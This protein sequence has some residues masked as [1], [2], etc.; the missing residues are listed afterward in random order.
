[1]TFSVLLAVV[2]PT[3]GTV[4]PNAISADTAAGGFG[5]LFWLLTLLAGGR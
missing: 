1:M 2:V 5:I 4:L 3:N